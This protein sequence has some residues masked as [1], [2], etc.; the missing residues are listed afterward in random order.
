MNTSMRLS[1]VAALVCLWALAGALPAQTTA[2]A[3]VAE[4][5]VTFQQVD[6]P[7]VIELPA[8][9][10]FLQEAKYAACFRVR[11]P[12]LVPA[13]I[14]YGPDARGHL[15]M[16][17]QETPTSELPSEEARNFLSTQGG[18]AIRLRL[19]PAP[20]QAEPPGPLGA[21]A[22]PLQSPY[23]DE[24]QAGYGAG[25]WAQ[26][27][28]AFPAALLELE[29]L[30]P[31]PE[32]AEAWARAMI[33]VYNRG[34]VVAQRRMAQGNL[35]MQKR[36]LEQLVPELEQAQAQAKEAEEVISKYSDID[37]EARAALGTKKWLLAVDVAGVQ[38]RIEHIQIIQHERDT[39]ESM[40]PELARMRIAASVDLAD[41]RAR[42][43]MTDQFLTEA[44]KRAE[45]EPAFRQK[46]NVAI[47]LQQQ[48][49]QTESEIRRLELMLKGANLAPLSIEGGKVTIQPI[50]WQIQ[51]NV[52]QP[53]EP[54]GPPF[55]PGE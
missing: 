18:R 19:A 39:P 52:P 41:L 23:T 27:V 50:T 6:T 42:L 45:L 21:G 14:G 20:E 33:L 29:V 2:T 1:V 22:M 51:P 15:A 8:P 36:Q 34:W 16:M 3:P 44:A 9:D 13:V 7:V 4:R 53:G 35:D 30:A 28:G 40:G 38:A 54:M 25:P 31:S 49:T 37:E 24:E 32:K 47:M 12:G 48:K 10:P 43:T 46:Q 17:V 5:S 55:R 11:A 26:P